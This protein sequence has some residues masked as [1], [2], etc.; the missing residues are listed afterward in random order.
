M[1][2]S[3]EEMVDGISNL[4]GFPAVAIEIDAALVD[5]NT[6]VDEIGAIV[7]KDPAMSVNLLRLANSAFYN[8]GAEVVSVSQ[9]VSVIGSR[10]TRDI[11][12][13]QSAT[14]AFKAFP[15]DLLTEPD[16]WNHS[17]YC[18]VA[19]Q[20]IGQKIGF[21]G[22]DGLYTA[23]LLHDIGQLIMFTICPDQSRQALQLSVEQSDG[24][25]PHLAE[26]EI[27]GFDHGAVGGALARK[28]E[29][30]PA[31]QACIEQH[32][33]EPVQADVPVTAVDIVRVASS[34]SVLAELMSDDIEES[35]RIDDATLKRMNLNDEDL[36]SVGAAT[37]E[38]VDEMMG[39]F[40]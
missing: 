29:L 15:N 18:A 17:A 26:R 11:V 12:F 7:Q 16:F 22:S 39:A 23:G 10:R 34:V 14:D 35:P 3:P 1:A 4:A 33:I 5:E 8:R 25:F 40:V 21:S 28:W 37:R 13:T 24:L 38:Q 32:H 20:L 31:L 27:F 2:M 36:I 6:G 9:A 30:P 19:A